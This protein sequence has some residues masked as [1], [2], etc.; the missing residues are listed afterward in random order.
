MTLT[1]RSL[2][3]LLGWAGTSISLILLFG[4]PFIVAVLVSFALNLLG[5]M[6]IDID[7]DF[8]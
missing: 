3:F 7:W 2:L 1:A 8:F 5:V 4:W 6:I